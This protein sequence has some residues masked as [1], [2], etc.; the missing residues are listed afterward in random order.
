MLTLVTGGARSGKSGFAERLVRHEHK[1]GIYIATAQIYDNEMRERIELHRREREASGFAW[2]TVE[3]PHALSALLRRLGA[4]ARLGRG[5]ETGGEAS[6]GGPAVNAAMRPQRVGE[7]GADARGV[8]PGDG[9]ETR[10]ERAAEAGA[11]ANGADQ[12]GS[13][14]EA[15]L[16]GT[17]SRDEAPGV[18]V[19]C[20][21][22][23]LSNRLLRHE[24]EPERDRLLDA[25]IGELVAAAAAFPGRLTIVTN[26]VGSG[27]VPEYPL[28]RLYRDWAGRLNRLM[29]ERAERVFLVT[30]GIPVELKQ[31]Q[32]RFPHGSSGE[33]GS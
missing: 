23:W 20:L 11:D 17:A 30:A 7:A 27:I 25:E 22:L 31:L 5:D 18:L 3:E 14:N 19:D 4:E 16:A 15:L 13:A 21:T 26:E 24:H 29:A 1:A 33:G 32:Y 9:V 28:G 6:G 8:D 10:S 12:A 2:R